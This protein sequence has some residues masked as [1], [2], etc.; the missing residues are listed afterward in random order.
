MSFRIYEFVTTSM[1]QSSDPE[2]AFARAFMTL[3]WVLRSDNVVIDAGVMSESFAVRGDALGVAL[4]GRRRDARL[5]V[6][7][8]REPV[9]CPLLVLA[10]YWAIEGMNNRLIF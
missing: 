2:I 4:V 6:T 7:N 1:L 5:L 3:S 10:I 9:L 8:R